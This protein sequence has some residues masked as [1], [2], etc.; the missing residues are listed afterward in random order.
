MALTSRVSV[1]LAAT[2]TGTAD[3]GAP[4]SR[5]R[6]AQQ[7]DLTSGTG[8]GRADK[9]WTD[10]RT[11]AASG[12]EDLDLAGSLTDVY[13]ATITLA[14]VKVLFVRAAAA[15]TNDVVLGGA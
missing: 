9:L 10:Q 6:F 13:G 5:V 12:T 3:F 4:S 8:A 2:L 11:L 7:L 15:N 1:E 14:T